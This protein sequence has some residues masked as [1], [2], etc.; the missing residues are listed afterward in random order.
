[1]IT[2]WFGQCQFG[3]VQQACAILARPLP[4]TTAASVS[5]IGAAYGPAYQLL[6]IFDLPQ[7]GLG[8][9][10]HTAVRKENVAASEMRGVE[11]HGR[12]L[13]LEPA[14]AGIGVRLVQGVCLGA[15]QCLAALGDTGVDREA[16]LRV[17]PVGGQA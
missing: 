9:E 16:V 15:E 6:P 12:E 7:G 3:C 14:T 8:D 5:A 11:L 2:L 13:R 10:L 4:G 1:M 17:H